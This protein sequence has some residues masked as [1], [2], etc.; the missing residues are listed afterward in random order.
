MMLVLLLGLAAHYVTYVI[1][2]SN[3]PFVEWARVRIMKR[4]GTGWQW[5]FMHCGWC[6]SAWTSAAV[7]GPTSIWGNVPL[8]VVV[9]LAVASLSGTLI[10]LVNGVLDN[11]YLLQRREITD[12]GR[13]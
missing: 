5:E 2:H 11:K 3:F 8:P 9:W 4:W 13:S 10:L 7:V 1:T 6:M 12:R